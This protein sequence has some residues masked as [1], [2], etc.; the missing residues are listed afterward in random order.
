MEL[1]NWL[2]IDLADYVERCKL[3]HQEDSR[4]R[5]EDDARRL[6]HLEEP[7]ST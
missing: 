5:V 6:V 2:R 4:R 3:A 7:L 1:L